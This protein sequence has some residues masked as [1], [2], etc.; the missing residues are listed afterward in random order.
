MDLSIRA[1]RNVSGYLAGN[2][3]DVR[4]YRF[5]LWSRVARIGAIFFGVLL[6]VPFVFG[7][8]RSSGAGARSV[9]GLVL[10]LAWFMLQKMVENG[11]QAFDL[12]PVLLAWVPTLALG[13]L[14]TV[15][16]ARLR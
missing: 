11:T 3:Q 13:G 12:N 5:A 7:S 6:A 9:L 2:G 4:E 14:V 10:G 16:L 1:L 8:L 15:M